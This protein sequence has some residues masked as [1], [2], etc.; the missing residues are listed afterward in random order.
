MDTRQPPTPA[1]TE[2]QVGERPKR[3][4]QDRSPLA[5]E[6]T[7]RNTCRRLNEFDLGEEFGK[8]ED[9]MRKRMKEA[10]AKAPVDV[11]GYLSEA[12]LSLVGAM[13]SMMN[14]ISDGVK[15]ERM[16]REMLEDR[17]ED[18]VKKVTEEVK[19]QRTILDS[20]TEIRI[21]SRVRESTKEMEDKIV[22][23]QCA[24]KLLDIDI[25]CETEDKREIVRK[26]INSLRAYTRVEDVKWLDKILSR[27]KIVILGRCTVR[28]E[29]RSGDEY[30]VPT[31][32]QC[33][34]R[35]DTEDLDGM[36]REA[37]W[38][39]S[40]HWPKEVLEMV[41]HARD[42]VRKQ[43]YSE[44]DYYVKVRPERREGRIMLRAEAKAKS[45]GRYMLKGLFLCP[46]LHRVLWDNVP[47]L[48]R[49]QLSE[50]S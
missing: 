41:N 32:F 8:V 22:E 25:G 11:R 20:L 18:Q 39:P 45:G 50:R 21:K 29:G 4:V 33:R 1:P 23:A 15:Q 47:D 28:R 9:E 35:R 24:V 48:M 46:P 7:S 34:D 3:T 12:M 43:G 40:F 37:G 44:R 13:T 19:E 49:S 16:E 42:E 6:D 38:Y 30:T 2:L 26:T 10:V 31:L 27:T 36:L 14:N 17:M 5:Q